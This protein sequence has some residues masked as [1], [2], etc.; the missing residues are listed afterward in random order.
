MTINIENIFFIRAV[1]IF[2]FKFTPS[3]AP[4]T[5]LTPSNNPACKFIYPVYPGITRL[6]SDTVAYDKVEAIMVNATTKTEVPI[7]LFVSIPKIYINNGTIMIPPP[8][9]V[10][11]ENI[12]VTIPAGIKYLLDNR[13]LGLIILSD[14]NAMST[15]TIRRTKLMIYFKVAGSTFMTSFGNKKAA[16]ILAMDMINASLKATLVAII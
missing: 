13:S 10:M 15:A 2:K 12:P 1:F 9:P 7:A 3:S 16:V 8:N 4:K 5:E 6:C 14:F 11:A